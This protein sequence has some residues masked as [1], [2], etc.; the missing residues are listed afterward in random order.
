MMSNKPN[1]E[2]NRK[3]AIQVLKGYTITQVGKIFGVTGQTVRKHT[4][5]TCCNILGIELPYDTSTWSSYINLDRLRERKNYLIS[6]LTKPI[7]EVILT[8]EDVASTVNNSFGSDFHVALKP[9]VKLLE[10]GNKLRCW[11]IKMRIIQ[12]KIYNMMLNIKVNIFYYETLTRP[13]Y[14]F[15]KNTKR[16]SKIVVIITLDNRLLNKI[17]FEEPKTWVSEA[18]VI[19]I[20]NSCINEL[21]KKVN[22]I[23]FKGE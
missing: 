7:A 12:T 1:P 10:G 11:S 19:I 16:C 4:F 17:V 6:Q 8:E 15:D 22:K 18:S 3:M 14:V 20:V 23:D 21:K 9:T 2:R 5:R 13:H